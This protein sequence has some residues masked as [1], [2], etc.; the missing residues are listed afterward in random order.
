MFRKIKWFVAMLLVLGI[1]T[2]AVLAD[3]IAY[4]PFEEGQGTTTVDI[5]GNGNDGTFNGSVEWV[6]GYIGSAV[7]FDTAGERILVGPL[8][9][10]EGTNAMTLAAWIF[11]EGQG[12]SI[13]HQGI[14]GKRL[15][16]TTTGEGARVC[17]GAIRSSSPMRMSGLT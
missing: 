12:H 9:P 15:G 5:T 10:T 7:S 6:P 8:D 1:C 4:W 17:G 3:L 16:W 13:E 2:D 14:I 11:W